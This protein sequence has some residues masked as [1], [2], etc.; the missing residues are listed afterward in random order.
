MWSFFFVL[1]GLRVWFEFTWG[2]SIL[3]SDF[4]SGGLQ[5]AAPRAFGGEWAKGAMGRES[6]I[7][8]S[9][10]TRAK[11]FGGRVVA[12]NEVGEREGMRRRHGG[13]GRMILL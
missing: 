9:G 6:A 13:A 4:R 10:Q 3:R 1:C 12:I 7:A 11:E 8:M 2:H 5:G